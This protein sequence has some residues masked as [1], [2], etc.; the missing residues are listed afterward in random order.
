MDCCCSIPQLNTL[1]M[2]NSIITMLLAQWFHLAWRLLAWRMLAWRCLNLDSS[3]SLM[4]NVSVSLT[5]LPDTFLE[6]NCTNTT[7]FWQA[8]GEKRK[9]H[10]VAKCAGA[11]YHS[12]TRR[13]LNEINHSQKTGGGKTCV[14]WECLQRMG[15]RE[16]TGRGRRRRRTWRKQ[17][18]QCFIY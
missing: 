11:C 6:R 1:H 10:N 13:N 8:N 18:L 7:H 14:K 5:R 3:C 2:S 4:T 9:E 12:T 16:K 15:G 17:D